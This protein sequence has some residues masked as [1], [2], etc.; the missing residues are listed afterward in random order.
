MTSLLPLIHE[1]GIVSFPPA[2]GKSPHLTVRVDPLGKDPLVPA[3]HRAAHMVHPAVVVL[4]RVDGQPEEGGASLRGDG[5]SQPREDCLTPVRELSE[6]TEECC[7]P[8]TSRPLVLSVPV[9]NMNLN[10]SSEPVVDNV[11]LVRG[12]G[13]LRTQY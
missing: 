3:A 2:T 12:T 9:V 10:L 11:V 5:Q 4:R 13:L 8:G 1:A 7:D 6:I